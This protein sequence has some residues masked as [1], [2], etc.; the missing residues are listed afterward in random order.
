MRKFL[1]PE[2]L[3]EMPDGTGQVEA[4]LAE[5]TSVDNRQ[6]GHW[7]RLRQ[8]QGLDSDKRTTRV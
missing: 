7:A 2:T 1:L 4:V 5:L 6:G 3:L 8:A